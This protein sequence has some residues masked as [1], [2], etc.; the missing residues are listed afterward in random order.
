LNINPN[1]HIGLVTNEAVRARSR[2]GGELSEWT[3]PAYVA[4]VDAARTYKED[5]GTTFA[6]L[7][8]KSI[9]WQLH[10]HHHRMKGARV[11]GSGKRYYTAK[12][13]EIRRARA[14][15]S[16]VIPAEVDPV[17]RRRVHAA[18]QLLSP[19]DAEV[20]MLM[21]RGYSRN[22]ASQL[23]GGRDS[24]GAIRARIVTALSL[25][26]IREEDADATA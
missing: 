20:A 2:Y 16:R 17:L 23:T 13:D 1:E 5:R 8:V 6:T 4:L 7:A 18:L 19:R 22:Q 14:E 24:S 21:M 25:A 11:N 3:G 9:R 12:D 15:K 10:L 26:G